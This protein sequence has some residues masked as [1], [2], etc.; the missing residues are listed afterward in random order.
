[1]E[2]LES[3]IRRITLDLP[4]RPGHV[5]AYLLDDSLLVDTGVGLPDARERWAE[6]LEG[7]A[8]ERLLV[9]HFHPDHVGAAADVA[10]LTGAT[11]Y[12]G[13][14][15]YA[16][17]IHVWPN[18]DWPE[19]LLDWFVVNGVPPEITADLVE[20]GTSFQPFIHFVRDPRLL[21]EGDEL[22][23]W[24][25]L[26]VPGHADG[27]LALLRDGVLVSGDF[28]LDP[29]TPAIGWWPD[30]RPDPLGDYLRSLGRVRELAPRI[31]YPGH[32][33][34][35]LDPVG[36]ADELIE[37]HRERLETT[38]AS[39]GRAPRTGY[40]V[41]L[42]LF[43]RELRPASRRFAVAET[44]SHLERL[45]HAGRAARAEVGGTRAYTGP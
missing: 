33:E 16:Q 41:S 8:V 19:R 34:P 35:I 11:V 4:M 3:G 1:M 26:E 31:A 44:L 5:H 17:C 13:A 42:E 12:Q 6:R 25:V 15:D 39:L 32:G 43:G 2:E 20:Q 10:G 24:R 28:L 27:H 30:S 9:T 40:E 37:H 45:V 18:D 7:V 36:R 23:G 21:Y 29:I 38:E 22:D 14:L